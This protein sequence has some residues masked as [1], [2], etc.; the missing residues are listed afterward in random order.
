[1]LTPPT[2]NGYTWRQLNPNDAGA[3][4]RL[5]RACAPFDGDTAPAG[6]AAY[7][8]RLDDAGTDLASNTICAV[9]DAGEI[10]AYAWVTFNQGLKQTI[11]VFQEGRIHPEFRRRG[12]GSFLVD[13][14]EA[15][16]QQWYEAVEDERNLVLRHDFYDRGDDA[17]A[18]FE[19]YGYTF[20]FAEDDMR[21]DL[22]DSIPDETLPAGMRVVPWT[23][24]RA[25]LFHTVY[26]DAF[27]TRG[28]FTPWEQD[29]WVQAYTG[30]DDF[31]PDLSLLVLEGDEPVGYAVCSVED[32]EGWIVQ[33]GVRPAWRSRGIAGGLLVECMQRFRAERLQY[34]ML[35][36]NVNNPGARRVYERLGFVRTTRYTSYQKE[37]Q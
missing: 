4:H 21:F 28:D 2:L 9:N 19:R 34:A 7:R 20:A 15:R 10:A 14:M 36:V 6:E 17:I 1:M 35:N 3:L 26:A 24:E 22:N 32:G 16:A 8:K 12:V 25:G 31:R 30:Y 18:L 11:R 33:M 29:A 5:E 23:A 27:R 13:W 37:A